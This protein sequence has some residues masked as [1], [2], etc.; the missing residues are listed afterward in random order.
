MEFIR[1]ENLRCL[2]DTGKIRIKPLTILLG[3]NSS[4]KSTFL[5]AFPLFRQSI[6]VR[7]KGPILWTGDFVDFGEYSDVKQFQNDQ[8][9]IAFSL[10]FLLENTAI[11]V[12]LMED[13]ERFFFYASRML[14]IIQSGGLLLEAR[15]SLIEDHNKESTKIHALQV[16]I[17][18]N[19]IQIETD[20]SGAVRKFLVNSTDML[21]SDIHYVLTDRDTWSILPQIEEKS[22][23]KKEKSEISD[24]ADSLNL[25]YISR[26][27][28]RGLTKTTEKLI[29]KAKSLD[30]SRTGLEKIIEMVV[31]FGIGDSQSMLED[32]K[33]IKNCTK[34]WTKNTSS[35]SLESQDFRTLRDL[36]IAMRVPLILETLDHK[37]KD[38]FTHVI[39]IGPVR[40]TAL[41]FYRT[42]AFAVEEIDPQGQNLAMFLR[43]L[44]K[45]EMKRFN[46]WTETNLGFSVHINNSKGLV[47]VEIKNSDGNQF[48][49]ADTGFGF[50]QLLPIV[51]QLWYLID[52]PKRNT[53]RRHTFLS[54]DKIITLAIEQPEL[55]LHPRL[56]K[57]LADVFALA[58][59]ESRKQNRSLKI[60]IET[61]SEVL[62]NRLG[63]LIEKD[64]ELSKEVNIV[65]FEPS[66]DPMKTSV[67][68][69]GFT[70]DGFLESS[71]PLGF[72]DME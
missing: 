70:R 6:E 41:R 37:I 68:T 18:D 59:K 36:I 16:H 32:I 42:Q 3:Q 44:K 69:T 19:S 58:V 57:L 15:I 56:H 31:S 38:Y 67:R 14:N 22:L 48:N 20:K 61:H 66:D 8:G 1:V 53:R 35:W 51:T 52:Q 47:S 9:N 40:A 17:G 55:H 39:Y 45:E 54:R 63:M 5:R 2:S 65:L 21:S 33:K 46:K 34:T 24:S 13:E 72:F 28:S 11:N 12:N 29:E 26:I 62:I 50:S 43:N 23:D 60:L 4:G 7:T 71:W 49:I 27:V 30:N 25:L 64:P 10:G